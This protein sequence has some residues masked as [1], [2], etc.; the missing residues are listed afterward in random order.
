VVVLPIKHT[1]SIAAYIVLEFNL[2]KTIA[3]ILDIFLMELVF[4]LSFLPHMF[5]AVIMFVF[6]SLYCCKIGGLLT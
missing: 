6:V 4:M 3:I 1:S 2:W 5:R